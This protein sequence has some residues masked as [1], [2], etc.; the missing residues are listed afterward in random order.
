MSYIL[1]PIDQCA[2]L[3][4][5]LLGRVDLIDLALLD[6]IFVEQM[7]PRSVVVN[8]ILLFSCDRLRDVF[9]IL[10]FN[11]NSEIVERI[12]KHRVLGLLVLPTSFDRSSMDDGE[13]L[14]EKTTDFYF[15]GDFLLV[16]TTDLYFNVCRLDGRTY[17]NVGAV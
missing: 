4:A 12:Q 3:N 5:G 16:K 2:L 9:P 11:N 1:D 14:L 17:P 15:D 6:Y 10:N 8:G 7:N 13:F